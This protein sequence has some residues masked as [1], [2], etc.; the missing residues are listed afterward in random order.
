MKRFKVKNESQV[1]ASVDTLI[2]AVKVLRLPYY[3]YYTLYVEDIIED[4]E[5][6]GDEILEAFNNGEQPVDLN[7]F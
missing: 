5:V 3:E 6:S 4:I 2:D 1:I 7:F